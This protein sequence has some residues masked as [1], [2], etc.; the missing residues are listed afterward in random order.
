MSSLGSSFSTAFLCLRVACL[1][2]SRDMGVPHQPTKPTPDATRDGI[3]V[4]IMCFGTVPAQI[5]NPAYAIS[6]PEPHRHVQYN[7][8]ERS[9]DYISS[10]VPAC[11]ESSSP[12]TGHNF[13]RI[14]LNSQGVPTI[15]FHLVELV[16]NRWVTQHAACSCPSG[17]CAHWQLVGSLFPEQ[18][19]R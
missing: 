6:A 11:R 5:T 16:G 7:Q 18:R 10:R 12:P 13:E 17:A 9:P 14:A 15:V 8:L 2:R 19:F 3:W 4:P 1:D